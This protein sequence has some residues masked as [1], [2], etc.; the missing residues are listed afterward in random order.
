MELLNEINGI[1]EQNQWICFLKTA[2]LFAETVK[3]TNQK[4]QNTGKDFAMPLALQV[5]IITQLSQ[6]LCIY[7]L[8][9]YDL[10]FIYDLVIWLFYGCGCANK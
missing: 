4:Q 3:Q 5:N 10:L 8:A 7:D 9:I 2:V 6:A 1:A